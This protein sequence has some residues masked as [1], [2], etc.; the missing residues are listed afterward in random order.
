MP[1]RVSVTSE[2]KSGRN[3]KFHDNFTGKNMNRS[4]FVQPYRMASI[5]TTPLET[6][7][8]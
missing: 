4:Q 7:M 8:A 1:K 5:K 6:C 2:N 3:E